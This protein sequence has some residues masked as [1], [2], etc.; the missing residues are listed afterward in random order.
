MVLKAV[1]KRNNT[2]KTTLFQK[3]HKHFNCDLTGKTFAVWGLSFKPNTD[4]MREAPSRVLMEALWK[5]GA[6]VQ[7]YDP[8]A[9]EETQRIYGNRDNLNLC[10]TKESALKGADALVIVTEWQAFRAPDFELIKQS[11]SQ[12]VVF[13]GRNMFEPARMMKK[14]F[15]YYSIGRA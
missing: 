6:K 4:D 3:I 15:T 11:L 9:M 1:E 7:A 13:D 10:G 14:G 2:Q 12:P 8:E 5:A